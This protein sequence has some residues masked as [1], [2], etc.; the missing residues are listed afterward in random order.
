MA[1]QNQTITVLYI[2][3]RT[4]TMCS[5]RNFN[6]QSLS[7]YTFNTFR[8]WK[9]KCTKNNTSFD[10]SANPLGKVRLTVLT[11]DRSPDGSRSNAVSIASRRHIST[12]V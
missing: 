5:A 6:L 3:C 2:Q 7:F 1:I 11:V 4:F 12:G 10:Q 8:T 9:I